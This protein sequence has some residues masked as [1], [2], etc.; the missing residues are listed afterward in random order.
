MSIAP[1]EPTVVQAASAPSATHAADGVRRTGA[2]HRVEHRLERRLAPGPPNVQAAWT[3]L[4][5]ATSA[6]S[7]RPIAVRVFRQLDMHSPPVE[8]TSELAP[9]QMIRS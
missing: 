3:W 5:A 9:A 8:V 1:T 2:E 4:P 6:R 7:H